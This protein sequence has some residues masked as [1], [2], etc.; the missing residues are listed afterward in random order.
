MKIRYTIVDC[1]LGKLLI[2][3]TERG[4]CTIKFA[5]STA[6]LKAALWRDYPS[7]EIVLDDKG[8]RSWA[9]ALL[10]YFQGPRSRLDLPVDIQGTAFQRRVW[11]ELQKIPYGQTRSYSEIAQAIGRPK[12]VRAVARACAANP[13]PILIPCHRV[14]RKDGT[15]GGYSSEIARKRALLMRERAL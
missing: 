11:Q 8:L 3:A 10:K 7:A 2:G 14:I 15:L 6:H 13:V 4:I 9:S 12:A 1:S 5:I